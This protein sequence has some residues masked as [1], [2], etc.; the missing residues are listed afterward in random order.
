MQGN[1]RAPVWSLAD[2]QQTWK[3]T[4]R[5]GNARIRPIPQGGLMSSWSHIDALI[6]AMPAMSYDFRFVPF[7][8]VAI[9]HAATLRMRVGAAKRAA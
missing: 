4:S 2:A 9:C 7:L 8:A 3:L 6:F 5:R 1:P